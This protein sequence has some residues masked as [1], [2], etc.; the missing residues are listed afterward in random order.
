VKVG[1]EL[2]SEANELKHVLEP[3]LV[4][5]LFGLALIL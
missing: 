5:E 3:G 1:F 4:Q 2:E